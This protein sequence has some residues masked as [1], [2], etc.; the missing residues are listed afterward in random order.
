MQAARVL[1]A[2]SLFRVSRTFAGL[3]RY[4]QDLPDTATIFSSRHRAVIQPPTARIL[5]LRSLVFIVVVMMIAE[6]G[7][8]K[9]RHDFVEKQIKKDN[10]TYSST[11]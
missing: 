6:R 8:T 3:L 9:T 4:T 10:S 1:G 7:P 11:R 2:A 5:F